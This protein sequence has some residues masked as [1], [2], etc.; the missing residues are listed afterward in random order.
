MGASGV[1]DVG[2]MVIG[3]H[4]KH[5]VEVD[6]V[7]F[8]VGTKAQARFLRHLSDKVPPLLPVREAS[9]TPLFVRHRYKKRGNHLLLVP[10]YKALACP[11]KEGQ[12]T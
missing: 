3:L 4:V 12:A 5:T 10:H 8:V 11:I 7:E 1:V 6:D 2:V 9:Y